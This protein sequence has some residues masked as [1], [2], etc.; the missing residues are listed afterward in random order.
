MPRGEHSGAVSPPNHCLCP[1]NEN[2]APP[3]EDCAPKIV[4][5][6]VPLEYNSRPET[7]KIRTD[8]QSRIREQ[9]PTFRRFC[10]KDLF[11]SLLSNSRKQS[12]CAPPKLFIPPSHATLAPGLRGKTLTISY[13]L[14]ATEC[15]N[16]KFI[17]NTK[18]L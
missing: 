9:G 7:P 17:Q 10:G 11:L 15:G 16:L 2:C 5:G 4:T 1:P 18:I 13:N 8:H 12:F 14:Q 6:S 3:S